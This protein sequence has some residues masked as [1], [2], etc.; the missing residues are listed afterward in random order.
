MGQRT[1]ELITTLGVLFIILLILDTSYEFELMSSLTGKS[2]GNSLLSTSAKKGI[3]NFGPQ[4]EKK[5][6][7]HD[8]E[9]EDDDEEQPNRQLLCI[10]GPEGFK[11]PDLG[12]VELT[13]E[14]CEP[15]TPDHKCPRTGACCQPQPPIIVLNRFMFFHSDGSDGIKVDWRDADVP[16]KHF[17]DCESFIF[18][19][20]GY[21]EDYQTTA[22]LRTTTETYQKMGNCVFFVEWS[23]GDKGTY[24]QATADVRTVGRIVAFAIHKW[25]ILDKIKLVLGFSLGGQAI[26]ATAK[27]LKKLT[28]GKTFKHCHACD[29]AGPFFDGCDER[30]TLNP[31]D[32][33]T[34]QALHTSAMFDEFLVTGLELSGYGTAIKSG[35]CDY[36]VNCG[37]VGDQ[38]PCEVTGSA[39]GLVSSL[40]KLNVTE[41]KKKV[42]EQAAFRHHRSCLMYNAH[43]LGNYNYSKNT[44][45]C[46]RCADKANQKDL[47]QG[48]CFDNSN[49]FGE[50]FLL[51]NPC[52]EEADYFVS[53]S[54]GNGLDEACPDSDKSLI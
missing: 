39:M 41:T 35:K 28:G 23:R 4:K 1:S 54:K 7:N 52:E 21:Q 26:G 17:D 18:I 42:I 43:L 36:W 29:A 11:D 27:Q 53:L 33:E 3:K 45:L 24:Q 44:A 2:N 25:G 20:H 8:D 5:K 14:D 49:K 22:C 12:T 48:R 40:T 34:V 15:R 38:I 32:C 51:D 16:S 10:L 31:D 46:P 19:I 47:K 37:Y 13:K 6:G 50:L 9:D 30:V